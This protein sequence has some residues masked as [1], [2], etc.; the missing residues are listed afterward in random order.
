MII[1]G[2]ITLIMFITCVN[3][4]NSGIY[5]RCEY[6]LGVHAGARF[7]TVTIRLPQIIRTL[8]VRFSCEVQALATQV[9]HFVRQ[10]YRHHKSPYFL[11]TLYGHG[12]TPLRI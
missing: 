5:A 9:L 11:C 7:A 2:R 3:K 8:A 1:I 6:E 10:T 4:I 12:E